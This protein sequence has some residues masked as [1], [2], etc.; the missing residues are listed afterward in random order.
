MIEKSHIQL[1]AVSA[2]LVGSSIFCG[3]NFGNIQSQF[4][5]AREMLAAETARNGELQATLI[6]SENQAKIADQRYTNGCLILLYKGQMTALSQGKPVYDSV[7]GKPL[8]KGTV[9]CDGYGLTAVLE[10][11]DFDGDGKYEPVITQE[12]FTGNSE[13]I[14]NA[15]KSNRRVN[16]R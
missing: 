7:T 3:N 16:Y 12:A 10:P 6:S 4:G 9:V 8:P 13:V 14:G 5:K 11:R 15:I 1:F 2:L